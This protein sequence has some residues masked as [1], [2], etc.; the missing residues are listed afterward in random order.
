MKLGKIY[1]KYILIHVLSYSYHQDELKWILHKA[2]KTS[3]KFLKKNNSIIDNASIQI[4]KKGNL[5]FFYKTK[6]TK[7]FFEFSKY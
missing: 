7:Q 5:G 4:I 1:Q 2:C 3:R 6:I